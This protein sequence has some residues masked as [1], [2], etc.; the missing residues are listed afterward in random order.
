[1]APRLR[2]RSAPAPS[3]EIDYGLFT[4]EV[5][6][7]G[8]FCGSGSNRTYLDDRVDFFDY[9]EAEDMSILWLVDSL[10]RLGYPDSEKYKI[11]LLMPGRCITEGLFY[12]WCDDD[13]QKMMS[14][15]PKNCNSI[16][17]YVDQM[18]EIPVN[19]CDEVAIEEKVLEPIVGEG[20]NPESIV[21]EDMLQAD[22]GR[23]RTEEKRLQRLQKF[24][25]LK[26][27]ESDD[28]D[29]LDSDADFFDSD[30]DPLDGDDDIFA[31]FVDHDVIDAMITSKGKKVVEVNE[32]GKD[33]RKKK[34]SKK[35][36][37]DEELLLPDSDDKN[38]NFKFKSFAEHDMADPEFKIGM[39]FSTVEQLREAI[40]EYSIKNR[41]ALHKTRNCRTRVEVVCAEGCPWYLYVTEDSR[42]KSLL[43]KRY[44][45]EHTCSREW[46]IKAMTAPY[47]AKKYVEEIRDNENI[48]AKSFGN[49]VQKDYNL[50][51][52][53]MKLQ[54]AKKRAMAIIR[55][56]EE[57]QY[58]LL[59]DYAEEIRR[60]NHGSSVFLNLDANGLF[61]TMYFSLDACKRGFLEGCRP[62]LFFDG[63]HLKTR[64]GGVMLTAIGI[65]PNDCIFP[66]AMAVVDV[67]CKNSW[68]WFMNTLKHDLNI[69]DHMAAFTLMS[70]KQK[71]LILAV[72]EEFPDSEHRFCV[73]HLY[74]NFNTIHKGE[75]LKNQ[76]WACARSS[77]KPQYERN[78]D[79]LKA[80]SPEA[81][82]WLDKHPPNQWCRAF[83]DCFCKSD[84]LLNNHCEVFNN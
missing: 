75:V 82:A 67:E 51:P 61:E 20:V 76:L 45:N 39:T 14:T 27:E 64:H 81:Y 2:E 41:V 40:S 70:D 72:Q 54:R 10:E 7:N 4:L 32:D 30:N 9:C 24:K 52:G 78:M 43:V 80:L 28:S 22:Q 38:F 73:R 15:V 66:I 12:V 13:L 79:K 50:A 17:L 44:V 58:N 69:H 42:S 16:I 37:S 46:A 33:K 31:A 56:D 1:M 11:Y 59:W 63:C 68:K 8:F 57:K 35:E 23:L 21:G 29:R 84:T 18:F 19:I 74:Q 71:G 25:K 48:D 83:F 34:K 47:L 26:D 77:N 3:Y 36:D 62:I 60:S 5:H 53:R 49:K 55:G 65:D 6:H